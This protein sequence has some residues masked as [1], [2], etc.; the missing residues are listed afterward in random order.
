MLTTLLTIWLLHVA[1]LVTPGANVLLVSQLA[2]GDR[3]RSAA[4]AALGVAVGAA[5][6]SGAAVLGVDAVFAAFPRFRLALQVAGAAYLLYIASRLWRAGPAAT[7]NAASS[8]SP[9]AAFRLGL[10]T[11]AT[12]P[13]SALFFG[14]IFSA[15]LPARPGATLLVCAVA[16][17]VLNALSWHLFLAYV[18][19]RG[20]V[21]QAYARQ[22][23]L[24]NRLGG[25]LAGGF[26]LSLL[27]ASI[28]EARHRAG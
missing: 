18:F 7:G 1:A 22:S 21:R 9:A 5:L 3:A 15:A 6:W 13:K 16:L 12:N 4:F 25:A 11:N 14:S 27:A 24:L 26:G 2:A 8:P 23:R 28:R 19:S 17:V 20:R 10:L